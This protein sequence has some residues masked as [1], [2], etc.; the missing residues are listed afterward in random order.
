MNPVTRRTNVPGSVVS[1]G[2]TKTK[3]AAAVTAK[4]HRHVKSLLR[5]CSLQGYD[6]R[7]MPN[8][9]S[10]PRR[11]LPIDQEDRGSVAELAQVD[12]AAKRPINDHGVCEDERH[13]GKRNG[14]HDRKGFL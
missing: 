6:I 13:T 2:D 11:P 4:I 9:A 1:R 10:E 12:L 14:S 5:V 7:S 8:T 3:I